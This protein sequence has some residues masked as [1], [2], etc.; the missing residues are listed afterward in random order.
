M[1]ILRIAVLTLLSVSGVTRSVPPND[2]CA[3]AIPIS[4]FGIFPFDTRGATISQQALTYDCDHS[5]IPGWAGMEADV[6]FRWSAG[7]F[8]ST[9]D[10][11]SF[12]TCG[13]TTLDTMIALYEPACPGPDSYPY[14]LS[15][16]DDGC[17]PQSNVVE[18]G[19]AAQGIFIR[20]G[21]PPGL[22]GG[23]GW[24]RIAPGSYDPPLPPGDLACPSPAESSPQAALET[25]NSRDRFD[26][27]SSTRGLFTVADDFVPVESGSLTGVCWW[28]TYLRD[29]VECRRNFVDFFEITY[30]ADDC[31]A[32]G[33]I[34]AG[35]FS[36]EDVTM[37]VIGP[38][39]TFLA[40]P[41]HALEYQF[42]ASHD[43]VPLVGGR[44]Y[45]IGI[46]NSY[47][48]NCAWYWGL[49]SGHNGYAVQLDENAGR[50]TPLRSDLAFCS[51]IV[52]NDGPICD[53]FG[54]PN[55]ACADAEP[56]V[57]GEL[58][59]FD[60]Y[61]ATTDGPI[62]QP[63]HDPLQPSPCDFPLGDEQVHRDVW[64]SWE[65][66]C[67]STLRV[68]V[69]DSDFDTKLAVYPGPACPPAEAAIACA[70][71]G[72]GGE[73]LRQSQ[74]V[75]DAV[76][77]AVYQIRVGG[78]DG[79]FGRGT[80]TA[81]SSAPRKT[82]LADF[83]VF[84]RCLSGDDEPCCAFQDFD[85]DGDIDGDDYSAFHRTFVGP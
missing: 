27:V 44:T 24:L 72:C 67:N 50:M 82:S 46:T 29:G 39:D 3:D 32:P 2:E 59:E 23:A 81:E 1:R 4:G 40:Y 30:Y 58:V 16:D 13:L 19:F 11:I 45:W 36:Q 64:Y 85:A 10:P 6:W 14:A 17:M 33:E 28:G 42:S 61:G 43:P 55:D 79:D 48:N 76:A 56:L 51:R 7:Q 57:D 73:G 35:P 54:P 31:G 70:D 5:D 26:V 9:L 53:E 77:D 63:S 66:Q 38:L 34:V 15:C 69:C 80:L 47:Y 20:I 22:G 75:V 8:W 68:S 65:A 25:C 78:Y 83:A 84:T 49:A 60:T 21:S 62:N 12:S 74:V 18:S 37:D 71:D 41:N 52:E